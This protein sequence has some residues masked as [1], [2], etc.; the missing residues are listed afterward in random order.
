M[1]IEK[2]DTEMTLLSKD[3]YEMMTFF[4]KTFKGMF[5]MD[6]EEDKGLWAKGCV[7]QHGEANAMFKAFRQGVAYGA[8]NAI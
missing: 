1:V 4:E 2:G 3:H 8:S 7:Y 5:R 6:R